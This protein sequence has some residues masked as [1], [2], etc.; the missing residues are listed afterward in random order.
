M[1][2]I[3]RSTIQLPLPRNLFISTNSFLLTT[4]TDIPNRYPLLLPFPSQTLLLPSQPSPRSLLILLS[5]SGNGG[6]PSLPSSS[7][8]PLSRPER[9]NDKTQRLGGPNLAMAG[10]YTGHSTVGTRIVEHTWHASI[11]SSWLVASLPRRTRSQR[12]PFVETRQSYERERMEESGW[13]KRARSIP[14]HAILIPASIR[15]P[16]REHA[17]TPRKSSPP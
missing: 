6:H 13:M 11:T 5:S 7:F 9:M 17:R 10:L 2:A 14:A 16:D 8:S 12:R 1:S 3:R 15:R 4:P